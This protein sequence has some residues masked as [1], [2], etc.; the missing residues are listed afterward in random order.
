MSE[1][2]YLVSLE[3]ERQ[4]YPFYALVMACMRQADA[5][6]L[7]KLRAAW[8]AVWAELVHLHQEPGLPGRLWATQG[9]MAARGR[10]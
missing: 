2:D 7:E 6:N 10:K 1:F 4:G 3:I 5:D 8:P 9:K